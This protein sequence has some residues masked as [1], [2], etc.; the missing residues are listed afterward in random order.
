MAEAMAAVVALETLNIAPSSTYRVR[1]RCIHHKA[2]SRRDA[3]YR[4]E[5]MG[6]KGEL[7]GVLLCMWQGS[8]RV[9]PILSVT[10]HPVRKD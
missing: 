8:E 5:R 2:R 7:C 9:E 6:D 4:A 1:S 10:D 3:V